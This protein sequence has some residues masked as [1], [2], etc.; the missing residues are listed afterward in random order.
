MMAPRRHRHAR[1]FQER[2]NVLEWFDDVR[3]IKQ[4]LDRAGVFFVTDLERVIISISTLRIDAIS[5][6]LKIRMVLPFL[7]P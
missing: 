7:T 3:L 4:Y 6:E 1:T 5:T 2:K